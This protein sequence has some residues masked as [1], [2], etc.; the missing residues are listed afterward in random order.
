MLYNKVNQLNI[1]YIYPP[2]LWG[3]PD[4][5]VGKES[6]CS[7]TD[8]CSIP[9]LGRSPGE[10]ISY[11]LQY[12]GLENSMDCRGHGVAESDMTGQLSLSLLL[13]DLPPL[14]YPTHPGHHRALSW[15]SCPLEQVPSSYLFHTQSRIYV[16][17]IL[18][19]SP[20]LPLP[21]S[22]HMSVIYVCVSVSALKIDSSVPFF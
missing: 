8:P 1:L 14:L 6:T 3:F 15:A 13:M 12:F 20:T 21:H 7:A 19:F 18:P 22:I 11:P 9:G 10:G 2:R 5:S 17:P 16:N 4:S